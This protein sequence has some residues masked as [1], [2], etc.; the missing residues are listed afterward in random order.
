MSL[1][2]MCS[3]EWVESLHLRGS[4]VIASGQ[5]SC[6]LGSWGVGGVIYTSHTLEPLIELGLDTHTATKLALKLRAHS[7]QYAYELVSTRRTLEKTPSRVEESS[8][9]SSGTGY[10]Q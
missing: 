4:T 8:Q 10:C 5:L 3:G 1:G 9:L 7:V 2:F 6:V